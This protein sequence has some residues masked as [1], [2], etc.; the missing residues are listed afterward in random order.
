MNNKLYYVI[1]GMCK[2]I[3]RKKFKS[4]YR[5]GALLSFRGLEQTKKMANNRGCIHRWFKPQCHILPSGY[6]PYTLD[7]YEGYVYW[8]DW[9]KKAI[10]RISSSGGGEEI[11]FNTGLKKPM[12]VKICQERTFEENHGT[13]TFKEIHTLTIDVRTGWDEAKVVT[14]LYSFELSKTKQLMSGPSGNQLVLFSLES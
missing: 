14:V 2:A 4:S 9:G 12:G 7:I 6:H 1:S 11:M 5:F 10:L 8:A 13:T 3:L